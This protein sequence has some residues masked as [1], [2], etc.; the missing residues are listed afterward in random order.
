MEFTQVADPLENGNYQ[1]E[2]INALQI[3]ADTHT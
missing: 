3:Y 1:R 2:V